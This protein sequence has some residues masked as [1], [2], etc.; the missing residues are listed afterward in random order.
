MDSHLFVVTTG[1]NR[2][3]SVAS[4]PLYAAME[5]KRLRKMHKQMPI[6]FPLP[7]Q[8]WSEKTL[9]FSRQ[10]GHDAVMKKRIAGPWERA[11]RCCISL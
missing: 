11:C 5:A 6:A 10:D 7:I 3:W 9:P 8:V 2:R 1:V 4:T